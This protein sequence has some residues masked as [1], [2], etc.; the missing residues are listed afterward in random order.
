M[1]FLT[2]D[3]EEIL[4]VDPRY[5]RQDLETL[6]REESVTDVLYL[7]EIKKFAEEG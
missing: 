1:Q 5:Y 3:Y 4:V 7:Y 6:A 2:E